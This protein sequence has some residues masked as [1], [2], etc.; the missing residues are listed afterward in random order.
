MIVYHPAYDAHHCSYRMLSVLYAVQNN[1]LSSEMIR[2]IDFYYLYPHLLKRLDSLPRP[3]NYKKKIIDDVEDPFEITPNP[4]TLFYE[5]GKTQES[6]L[7]S[8]RNKSLFSIENRL[9]KLNVNFLSKRLIDSFENNS[10]VSE[11]VFDV[12]IGSFP[13]VN[14]HGPNGFKAKSGLMEFRYG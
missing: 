4:N 14:L 11:D 8:L 13:K 1:S 2:F 12:L 7:N 5:L 10:F 3:L 6:V 9:V